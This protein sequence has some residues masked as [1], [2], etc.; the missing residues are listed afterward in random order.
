M[1]PLLILFLVWSIAKPAILNAQC[2]SSAYVAIFQS[3]SVKHP[4]QALNQSLSLLR[5]CGKQR[6]R[7]G[8]HADVLFGKY[9]TRAAGCWE[10]STRSKEKWEIVGHSKCEVMGHPHFSK[11]TD[12]RTHHLTRRTR[13]S[14]CD[15]SGNF[16][17]ASTPWS[18][19]WNKKEWESIWPGSF[20]VP[21]E[22]RSPLKKLMPQGTSTWHKAAQV[23][24][25][26]PCLQHFIQVQKQRESSIR[27]GPRMRGHVGLWRDGVW[28][29]TRQGTSDK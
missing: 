14:T 26:Q 6:L 9:K 23:A 25:Q 5:S 12:P 15:F 22:K 4:S 8:S 27:I 16:S 17:E 1:F 13:P 28:C 19:P 24:T 11:V 10:T 18:S 2:L 3:E 7:Q 29:E 21:I 20:L